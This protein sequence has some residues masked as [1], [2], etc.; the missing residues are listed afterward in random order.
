MTEQQ[1]LRP[2]ACPDRILQILEA[3]Q[4]CKMYYT[5][6][7]LELDERFNYTPSE[8]T[9]RRAIHRLIDNGYVT[10]TME[11]YADYDTDQRLRTVSDANWSN[12]GAYGSTAGYVPKQRMMLGVA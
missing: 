7:V 12:L 8:S 9:I 10:K 3:N 2:R 5:Q 6:I 1:Q 4:P 11:T